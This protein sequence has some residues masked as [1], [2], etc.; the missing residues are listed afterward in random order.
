MRTATAPESASV[1]IP[2][3][4]RPNICSPTYPSIRIGSEVLCLRHQERHANEAGSPAAADPAAPALWVDE[5]DRD[6]SGVGPDRAG[7]VPHP[8]DTCLGRWDSGCPPRGTPD[9]QRT[10]ALGGRCAGKDDH[11]GDGRAGLVLAEFS[12]GRR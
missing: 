12:H 6:V 8:V 10:R 4:L 9:R 7:A 1:N 11:R 3:R 2:A 5:D